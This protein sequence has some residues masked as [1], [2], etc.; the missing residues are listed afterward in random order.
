VA[1]TPQYMPIEQMAGKGIDHRVD[2]FALGVSFFE[3]LTNVLPYPD[4]V[5]AFPAEDRP[6]EV[7]ALNPDIPMRL[8]KIIDRMIER[9]IE[10]RYPSIDEIERDFKSVVTYASPR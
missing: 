3:M 8:S 4:G 6:A 1:G 9:K 2:I 7:R 10:D 5:I